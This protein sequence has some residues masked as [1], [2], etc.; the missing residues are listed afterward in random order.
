MRVSANRGEHSELLAFLR[1]LHRGSVQV[2][3]K[4]GEPRQ[5]WLRVSA[6]ER[7][8]ELGRK[9]IIH[10]DHVVVTDG[11]SVEIA[12]VSKAEI[13]TIADDLFKEIKGAKGASFSCDASDV[14]I[15]V[16]KLVGAKAASTVKADLFLEVVSPVF[17]G[18][19][20]SLGFSVKSEL[21]GMPTLLNAGATQFQYRVIDCTVTEALAVQEA[22]P[23]ALGK[24]YPGPMR[25]LPA[26]ANSRA[27]VVFESVVDPVFEQN[28]KMI[29][30]EFP[31][32][33]ADALRHAYL[34]GDLALKDVVKAP[35]LLEELSQALSLPRPMVE[36]LVRHKVKELL[37]HS[38]L[39]MNPGRQWDGQIEAHGGWIIVKESGDIVCFHLI[40]DDD[41]RDYLLAN[42]KFDTPSMTRHEAGY[43]YR[44]G[45]DTEAK[46]RL[47]LQVRFF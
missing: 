40:N 29:D 35:A 39:G 30:T 25:L 19:V 18:E 8:S 45:E 16:L 21:G 28:L 41:F 3:D 17:Q 20:L 34:A 4:A 47:S 37:R 43:V 32:I 2:A 26:L 11:A 14:A 24:A 27:R 1:L 6:I 36:R 23:R 42:T 33:L 22:A 9:Y 44:Q 10:D 46:L 5:S 15:H 31:R 38:A 12:S 13:K 7:P